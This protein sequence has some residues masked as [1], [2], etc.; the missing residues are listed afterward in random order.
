[1]GLFDFMKKSSQKSTP[2]H[3]QETL[4]DQEKQIALIHSAE[5]KYE[6]DGDI[7]ALISF[8][9][10]IWNNGGLKFNGNKWI[11]RLPDLYIKQK[12]YDDALKIL[13]KIKNPQ[14]SDKKNSYIDRICKLKTKR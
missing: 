8:W 3:L 2:N 6:Q 14:Y 5:N 1:M 7:N 11:F 4:A 10:H 12:R 9:E 13:Q